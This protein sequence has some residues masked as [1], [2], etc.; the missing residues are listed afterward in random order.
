MKYPPDVEFWAFTLPGNFF[1]LALFGGLPIRISQ[2]FTILL[3]FG[4]A[5]LFFYIAHLFA[6]F[7]VGAILVP[8]LGHDVGIPSPNNPDYSQDIDNVWAYFA[9]WVACMLL[10]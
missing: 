3:D 10:L 1:L 7:I 4:R 9:T 8:L 6:V 5:A 2:R